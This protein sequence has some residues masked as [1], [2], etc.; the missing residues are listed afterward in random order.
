MATTFSRLSK[1]MMIGG[2]ALMLAGLIFTLSNV[3][4]GSS[5]YAQA[6]PVRTATPAATP[7]RTATPAAATPVRTA[8]PAA[9]PVR[10]ATPARV[11]PPGGDNVTFPAMAV[12]LLGAG[13]LGLGLFARYATGKSRV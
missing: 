3:G 6:T 5:A 4:T 9:T 2:G 10:T 8:T 11:L 7:V 12:A 1:W 13:L